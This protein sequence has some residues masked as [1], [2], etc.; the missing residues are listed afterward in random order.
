MTVGSEYIEILSHNPIASLP[1][2]TPQDLKN[3]PCILVSSKEQQENEQEY[4]QGVVGFQGE[5][6]YA[7]NLE[8]AHSL[9]FLTLLNE[10]TEEK[11]ATSA[12]ISL[13]WMLC[14]KP[15]IILIHR[16][17]KPGRLKDNFGATDIILTTEKI[18]AIDKRP[19]TMT[20]PVF[21]GH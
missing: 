11:Q 19:D 7:E 20:I 13:V 2:V 6:L 10:L 21:G 4:Y 15:F 18:A 3:V 9:H 8:E 14:K 12:Q 1:S 17:H 5:F 16:S